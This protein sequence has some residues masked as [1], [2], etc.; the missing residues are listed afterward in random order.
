MSV[1]NGINT[2]LSL[3]CVCVYVCKLACVC[4]CVY[5]GVVVEGGAPPW[6]S[7]TVAVWS[8]TSVMDEGSAIALTCGRSPTAGCMPGHCWR[9]VSCVVSKGYDYLRMI[10]EYSVLKRFCTVHYI[11]I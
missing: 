6:T 11:V 3:V 8:R 7:W 2:S 5:T 10:W 1:Y 9:D 4:V